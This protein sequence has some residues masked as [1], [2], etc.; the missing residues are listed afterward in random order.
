MTR[1]AGWWWLGGALLAAGCAALT[2]RSAQPNPGRGHH[3]DTVTVRDPD[4]ERRALR[5]E[6]EVLERDAEVADLQNRLDDARQEV[7]R[8]MAKLQTLASRAEAASGMAEAE[9]ALD[10]LKA[11][12]AQV[13][14]E[15]SQVSRLLQMSSAEFDRQNYG[16]ALYLANQA[17]DVAAAGRVRLTSDQRG[18]LRPGEIAFALPLRLQ[19]L[20]RSNVREGPGT[21][22]KVLFTIEAGTPLVARSYADVWV[23]INTDDGRSGWIIGS[24]VGR[25]SGSSP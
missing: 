13:A 9:I 3:V 24:L 21:T 6:L 8:A 16:G 12:G 14:P 7:V 4:A 10:S 19:A 25:G 18:T 5:A 23:R 11:A 17:K 15:V 22:F 2:G 1:R 20:G